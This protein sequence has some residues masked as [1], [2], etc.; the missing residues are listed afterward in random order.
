M[1]ASVHARIFNSDP[2]SL[3]CL[4]ENQGGVLADEMGLGKSAEILGLILRHP[5]P[6]QQS[7]AQQQMKVE[8]AAETAVPLG[9]PQSSGSTD[10]EDSVPKYWRI[11]MQKHMHVG[12]EVCFCENTT[13]KRAKQGYVQCTRCASW[14]HVQC[15]GFQSL[16]VR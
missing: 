16:E 11:E 10:T 2:R 9:S 13:A 3:S 5:A 1:S 4:I 6:A 8:A 15:A 12:Q 14:S 7:S